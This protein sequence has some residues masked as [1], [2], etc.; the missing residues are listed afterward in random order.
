M[1]GDEPKNYQGEKYMEVIIGKV[2]GIPC[3]WLFILEGFS[4][5]KPIH[6]MDRQ[7]RL[8]FDSSFFCTG[9]AS[10]CCLRLSCILPYC[11]SLYLEGTS[12]SLYNGFRYQKKKDMFSY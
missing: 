9:E 6:F 12:S 3:H 8:I 5:C 1:E 11:T 7:D 4:G 2:E 10:V